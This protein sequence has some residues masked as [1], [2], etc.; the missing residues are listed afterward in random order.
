MNTLKAA[1]MHAFGCVAVCVPLAAM[2][3]DWSLRMDGI[4]PLTLGLRYEEANRLVG[5]ALQAD[6]ASGTDQCYYASIGGHPH[7]LLMF[8]DGALRRVD[9]TGPGTATAEGVGVGDPVQRVFDAY[10]ALES[11]P[12]HYDERERYLTVRAPNGKLALRFETH[13]GKVGAFYAGRYKEVQYI[14]GCL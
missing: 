10:P 12:N 13:E 5:G 2:A 4:G 6:G 7:V 3:G 1:C 11:A 9:V 8:T 14:E